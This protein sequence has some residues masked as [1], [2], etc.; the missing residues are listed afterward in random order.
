MSLVRMFAFALIPLAAMLGACTSAPTS[1]GNGDAEATSM[2]TVSG[3]LTYFERIAL[4]RDSVAVVELRD[5]RADTVISEM[6][7]PLMGRQVPILFQVTEDRAR[8]PRG[9]TYAV[10]GGIIERGAFT[11]TT[12][13][14]PIDTGS[15]TPIDVGTLRMTRV[16]PPMQAWDCGEQRIRIGMAGEIMRLRVGEETLELR[17]VVT[18]SGTKYEAVGDPTTYLWNK[19]QS[20]MLVLRGRT[21]P[22]C[23]PVSDS[24]RPFRARGN[25]PN[26]S[27]E[28]GS[29]KIVF[30]D[31]ARQARTSVETPRPARI[32]GGIEYVAGTAANPLRVSVIDKLCADTMSGMP[33]PKTVEV[34]SDAGPPLRGCGG[35]PVELLVGKWNV[36]A[37]DGEAVPAGAEGTLR[38]DANGIISGK[39]FCNNFTGPYV[40]TGEG[41]SFANLATTMMA[42][43]EPLGSLETK[44]HAVL[45]AV[46][47][48]EI[49]PDGALVLRTN[50]GR[51]V[52]AQR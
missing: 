38:F 4:P 47:R 28:I 46:A 25:E 27:L 16:E 3:E 34:R 12:E 31:H 11:W 41:L 18:A 40:L 17:Q 45:K 37:I 24:G 48:F 8:F 7:I 19:G 13:V 44:L 49:A 14:V 22:E 6:R 9:G 20:S 35:E 32:E 39:A 42:C 1:P 15:A 26:W 52:V 36:R 30:T 29:D 23:V 50:D 51:S 21:L 5:A 33:F 2:L 10:R 43:D